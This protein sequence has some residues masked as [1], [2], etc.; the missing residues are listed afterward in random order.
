L[1]KIVEH[2]EIGFQV[3]KEILYRK[4]YD[5]LIGLTSKELKK[6]SETG[7]SPLIAKT[8]STIHSMRHSAPGD[9]V[10]S[11]REQK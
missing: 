11:W 1:I 8:A 7:S 6:S 9:G 10:D 4:V 2:Q 5:A 3:A